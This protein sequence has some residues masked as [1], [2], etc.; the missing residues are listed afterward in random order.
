[1]K[2]TVNLTQLVKEME[3]EVLHA[4]SDYEE[5]LIDTAD[6]NRPGLQ[7]TGF[8]DYFDPRRIQILG[9]VE[10]A[11]L[12]GCRSDDRSM[13]LEAL[14]R[15]RPVA[16]VI[17]HR[18]EVYPECLEAA[19]NM[20][21]TLLRSEMDTSEFMAVAIEYLRQCL[22]PRET[23][24]GVLVE[25]HGEGVLITGESG[26]GKSEAALELVKR[27]HRLIADDAVEIKRTTNKKLH[28]QAPAMIRHYMEL[29]GIGLID[30]RTL[31]GIGAVKSSVRIEL[32][33]HLEQWEP[34]KTYNRLG[35]EEET[36]EI[37]GVSLPYIIVPIRPGRNLAIILETAAMN[38]RLKRMGYDAARLFV[39]NHDN[40]I[41][42]TGW[43]SNPNLM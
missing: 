12:E 30:V 20:D 40:G 23:K 21:V 17:C 39:E 2:Y 19:K 16:V 42:P 37:L 31:Y 35:I 26:V 6:V 28:G 11:Y 10:T 34:G 5:T 1:M 22:A 32:V 43:I 7:L 4:A 41:E 24:H 25:I 18:V 14:M 13:R 9:R 29:R 36:T 8:F 27:G 33:V 15:R 3:L 38:N